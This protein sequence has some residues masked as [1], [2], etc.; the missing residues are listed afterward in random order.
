[1]LRKHG[2]V[3]GLAALCVLAMVA[4]AWCQAAP[5][6]SPTVTSGGE[7]IK[8]QSTWTM[9]DAI[10]AG[11]WIGAIILCLS[12]VMVALIIEHFMSINEQK[13]I[14][15][16]FVAALQTAIDAKRYKDA[17]DMCK[18]TDNYI[19][20]IMLVGLAETR[21]GYDAMTEAMFTASEEESIKLN[22]K[23]GYLSLIGVIAPMIGLL[24][25]VNGMMICFNTV[26]NSTHGTQARDLAYGISQKLVCTFE[27]L[28][29]AIPS[30]FFFNMFQDRVTNIGLEAGAVCEELI[31]N[32]KPVKVQ[33][34][35]A[36]RPAASGEAPRA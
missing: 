1:M 6:P 14:P 23:I 2:I 13:L 33:M 4:V 8:T 10:R 24:G 18:A 27:G 9:W 34:P 12:V 21:Y 35:A 36:P 26:A 22:Q 11:S 7:Q 31:R 17:M 3:L 16:D 19:S 28:A 20:R 15:P 32:F 25:T 30:M 5:A 29:V